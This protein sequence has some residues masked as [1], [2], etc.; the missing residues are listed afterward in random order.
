MCTESA[1]CTTSTRVQVYNSNMRCTVR[2]G[3]GMEWMDRDT[4]RAEG[5]R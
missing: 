3:T 1:G 4:R 5:V 2:F